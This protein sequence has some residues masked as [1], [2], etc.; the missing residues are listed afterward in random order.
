MNFW[1]ILIQTLILKASSSEKLLRH[2]PP[3]AIFTLIDNYTVQKYYSIF[4]YF[5]QIGY[6][7]LRAWKY[8]T[9]AQKKCLF[10]FY[11]QNTV[12]VHA[13]KIGSVL[14]GYLKLSFE[15]LFIL[16]KDKTT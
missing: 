10:S 4:T 14:L 1:W 15:G 7:T 11:Q 5:N 3:I 8:K 12:T 13:N 2:F 6:S 9:K 16:I